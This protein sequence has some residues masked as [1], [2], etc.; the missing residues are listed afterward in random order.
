MINELTQT[1]DAVYYFLLLFFTINYEL[2]LSSAWV[3]G[4]LIFF[5]VILS[6]VYNFKFRA[7]PCVRALHYLLMGQEER[8]LLIN[9]LYQ[10][11]DLVGVHIV[12]IP[13]SLAL[14]IQDYFDGARL[15]LLEDSSF[16]LCS[17]IEILLELIPFL[18]STPSLTCF[19]YISK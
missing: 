2:L 3:Q 18:Q 9:F 1:T 11:L 19:Q 13:F 15:Q 6:V 10:L 17:F 16:F 4:V 7:I 8:S 14:D 5:Y 12:L